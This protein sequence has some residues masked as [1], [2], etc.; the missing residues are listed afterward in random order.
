MEDASS[1]IDTC[2]SCRTASNISAV[3]AADVGAFCGAFC[4]RR[5][6]R[7][8]LYCNCN[9]L[10][11]S[12]L[13]RLSKNDA[14]NDCDNARVLRVDALRC[15]RWRASNL[16]NAVNDG[17]GVRMHESLRLGVVAMWQLVVRAL[18][19]T[20]S[21]ILPRHRAAVAIT[22]RSIVVLFHNMIM[23]TMMNGDVGDDGVGGGS[24]MVV[25]MRSN[26]AKIPTCQDFHAG[27]GT[28]KK[29]Q[30]D[31]T[32]IKDVSTVWVRV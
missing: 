23:A 2:S 16:R 5:A 14:R 31:S 4:S 22:A 8:C 32:F 26:R 27:C 3:T 19:A 28:T 6:S 24:Q 30:R 1:F 15:E 17:G 29:A 9:V 13:L 10:L 12:S 20:T 21:P 11:V 18:N 7:F 25:R